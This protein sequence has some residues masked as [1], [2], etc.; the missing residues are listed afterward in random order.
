MEYD[1]KFKEFADIVLREASEEK[2]QILTV[3]KHQISEANNRT[4]N[5]ILKKAQENLKAEIEIRV[6]KKNEAISKNAM[7]G[8]KVLIEKREELIEYMHNAVNGRLINFTKSAEYLYWIIEQIK[9]AQK[10]LEDKKV[11]VYICRNDERFITDIISKL[12]V[13][14]LI[15]DEITLGGCKIIS[16]V[17]RM[18]V[19]NTLPKKLDEAFS[20]FHMLAIRN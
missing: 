1:N 4:K 9:D 5:E 11:I 13:K 19:D 18:L 7:E 17:K 3:V 12:N 10:Q 20:N 16:E 6:R 15:D 2:Q 8:R 14:V